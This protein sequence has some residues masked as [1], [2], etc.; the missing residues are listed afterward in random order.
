MPLVGNRASYIYSMARELL[1]FVGIVMLTFMN[2]PTDKQNEI[3]II[4]ISKNKL[5]N[6]LYK[7]PLQFTDTC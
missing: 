5:G 3:K 6:S 1:S 2:N 7:A 4:I